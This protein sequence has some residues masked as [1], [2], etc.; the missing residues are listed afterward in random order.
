MCK[1]IIKW[2]LYAKIGIRIE[3]TKTKSKT[4]K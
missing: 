3:K 2:S 1:E 4:K